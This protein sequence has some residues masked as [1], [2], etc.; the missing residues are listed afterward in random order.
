MSR[1]YSMGGGN[2]PTLLLSGRKKY[3]VSGKEI[4]PKRGKKCSCISHQ[5]KLAL[6]WISRRKNFL[7]SAIN[8]GKNVLALMSRGRMSMW[9]VSKNV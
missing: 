8:E 1:C 6:A 7:V 2:A 9:F 5:E 4:I 3:P